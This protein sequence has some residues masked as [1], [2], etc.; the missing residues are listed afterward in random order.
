MD[1]IEIIYSYLMICKKNTIA[2]LH[3]LIT[4]ESQKKQAEE[5]NERLQMKLQAAN[6]LFSSITPNSEGSGMTFEEQLQE[7]MKNKTFN[8]DNMVRRDTINSIDLKPQ[9]RGSHKEFANEGTQT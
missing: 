8:D 1:E 5:E 6:H 2:K 9:S 4:M 3:R 7:V